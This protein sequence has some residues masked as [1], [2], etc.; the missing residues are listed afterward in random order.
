MRVAEFLEDYAFSF[1]TGDMEALADFYDV[2]LSLIQPEGTMLL[3]S[4]EELVDHL[5]A[6]HERYIAAGLAR[7]KGSSVE[8]VGF[9]EGLGI[10]NV[11]WEL[12]GRSGSLITTIATTYLLRQRDGI[13]RI[14]GVVR[15][16]QLAGGTALNRRHQGSG[17]A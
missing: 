10:L 7:V 13:L 3:H 8:E 5:V 4:R 2:P 1:G 15:L 16:D 14:A 17:R 6:R 11:R 9:D 12:H